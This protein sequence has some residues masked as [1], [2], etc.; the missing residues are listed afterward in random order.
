[1]LDVHIAEVADKKLKV[2]ED[3]AQQK[4]ADTAVCDLTKNPN[5]NQ[6]YVIKI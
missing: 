6:Q 4:P 5:D 2:L 1:V 3:F